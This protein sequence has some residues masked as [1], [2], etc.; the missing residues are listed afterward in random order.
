MT[1]KEIKFEL[2]KGALERY[3][4]ST[5]ETLT[6]SLKSLYEW[7]VEEPEVEV[8]TNQENQYD[9]IDIEE[10][11]KII[12]KNTHSSS[13][14]AATLKKVFYRNNINTVGDLLRIGKKFI[15][16]YYHIGSKTCCEISDALEELGITAW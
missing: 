5:N 4:F 10:V 6:E 12:R 15:T 13:P 14:M 7:I 8:E 11:L 9:S 3:T 16:C 2:A 1:N